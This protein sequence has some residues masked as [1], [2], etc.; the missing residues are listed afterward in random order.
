[1]ESEKRK[2]DLVNLEKE[3]IKLRD[4]LEGKSR[5]LSDHLSRREDQYKSGKSVN[6]EL[7]SAE[8]DNSI[9]QQAQ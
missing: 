6:H 4:T 2:Q 5:E 7:E 3:Q 9:K 8:K 1:M